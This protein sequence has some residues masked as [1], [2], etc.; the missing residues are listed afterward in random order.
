MNE[1]TDKMLLSAYMLGFDNEL[2]GTKID[3]LPFKH[4]LLV[5]AFNLGAGDALIGD[6]VR[7]VDYQS[8]ETLLNR[9][10]S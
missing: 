5:K 8:D 6:D 7:S 10:K 3:P 1:L 4:P 9:I 2:W